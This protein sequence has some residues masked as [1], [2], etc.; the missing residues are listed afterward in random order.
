MIKV[1]DSL[2]AGSF[3]VKKAEGEINVVTV[4]ELFKGKKVILVGVPGAFTSTCHYAHIPQFVANAATFKD[5]GV[6]RIVVI[7]VNDAHVMKAWGDALDGDAL[8]F[9]ADGNADYA[10][11]LGLTIDLS[12][13]GLGTRMKRFSA[14]VDDGVVKTLNFEPEGGKGI[15]TTGAATMLSQISA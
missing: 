15:Q 5:N 2:P 10:K 8:D 3:R 6:D 4:D 7:A 9:V 1:G 12:G 14:L 11:A 13:A